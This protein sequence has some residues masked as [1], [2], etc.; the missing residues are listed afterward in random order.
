MLSTVSF[1]G[2]SLMSSLARFSA[3]LAFL[4]LLAASAVGQ[5]KP[6]SKAVGPGCGRD[7][8]KFEVKTDRSQHPLAKPEAGKALVYF[9]QDDT[10]YLSRPRPTTRFGL[11]GTWVGATQS[12]AYFYLS[13]DPGEHH[14]CA[15][16]QTLVNVNTGG[17]SAAAHFNA[18]ADGAYFFIVRNHFLEKHGP[19]GMTLSPVDSDEAQLLMSK[20]GLS[21][22]HP[23]K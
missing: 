5:D 3:P 15:G 8:V 1:F 11:D 22:S 16:W 10:D 18:D 20:F 7:N 14:I 19:A 13:V 4:V 23:K 21:T 9:L 12:N 6:T 2:F 17:E